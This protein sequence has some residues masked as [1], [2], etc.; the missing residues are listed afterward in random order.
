MAIKIS[1]TTVI[2]DDKNILNIG[3]KFETKTGATGAV[4]HDFSV[5]NVF[6]HSSMSANFTTNITNLPSQIGKASVVTLILQQGT[7]P[8]YSN[9]LQI[10]GASQTIR[11]QG[12][13]TPTPTASTT[14]TE[15]FIIFQTGASTYLVLGQLGMFS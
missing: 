7:T 3:E 15:V 5:G 2:D 1:G 13:V 10:G 4:T 12:G 14:N 8:Y 9:A 6:L 11:W